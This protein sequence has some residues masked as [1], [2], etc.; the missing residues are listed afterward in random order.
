[1]GTRPVFL[2]FR[3]SNDFITQKGV[4]FVVN[5]SLHWLYNIRGVYLV[6]VSL[7]FNVAGFGTLFQVSAL[8]A[9]CLE[10]CANFTKSPE[11]NDHI[12]HLV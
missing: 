10:D 8:A 5:A 1:M 12:V 4:F 3:C 11:Q 9:N 7:L 6:Q 2:I